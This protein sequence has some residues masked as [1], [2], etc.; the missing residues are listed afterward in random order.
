[1]PGVCCPLLLSVSNVNEIEQCYCQNDF[2]IHVQWY[3]ILYLGVSRSHQV[4]FL[5]LRIVS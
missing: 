3:L 5:S 2:S 4:L 1:M